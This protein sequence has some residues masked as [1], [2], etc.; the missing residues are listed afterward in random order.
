MINDEFEANY[1]SNWSLS[2]KVKCGWLTLKTELNWS[3][4]C[5]HIATILLNSDKWS[6]NPAYHPNIQID[7]L[8]PKNF[9]IAKIKWLNYGK[10]FILHS[11]YYKRK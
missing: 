1:N 5:D 7:S 2:I 11:L 6:Q 3:Y 10:K 9:P 8:N 4:I